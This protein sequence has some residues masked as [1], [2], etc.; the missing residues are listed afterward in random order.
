LKYG[1]LWK[2]GENLGG[3]NLPVT[4]RFLQVS[5]KIHPF[6]KHFG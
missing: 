5:E 4:E 1:S 6:E 3:E 2:I